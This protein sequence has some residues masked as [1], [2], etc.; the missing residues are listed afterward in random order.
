MLCARP[1]AVVL[2][3]LAGC[4]EDDDT[5]GGAVIRQDGAIDGTPVRVSDADFSAFPRAVQSAW[6]EAATAGR[7][8]FILS[9]SEHEGFR[10]VLTRLAEAQ[11]VEEGYWEREGIYSIAF[12]G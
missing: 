1:F 12:L 6:K 7:G 4:I 2:L 10:Q 5:R 8:S 3:L 11:G 9:S